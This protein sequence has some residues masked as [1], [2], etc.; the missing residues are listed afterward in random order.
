[1]DRLTVLRF[2]LTIFIFCTLQLSAEERPK[3]IT[4]AV[5]HDHARMILSN[6]PIYRANWEFLSESLSSMGYS[7]EP[8]ISPWARAKLNVQQAEADGLFLAANL[9]GRENWAVLSEPLGYG[10]FGGFYH[11]DRPNIKSLVATIRLGDGDRIL[12]KYNPQELFEVATAQ[13]GFRLLHLKKVDRLIMS[14]SYGT[15]LLETSLTEYK[16]SISF[17]D[18]V[19][20]QRSIHIAFSK[21]SPKSLEALRVVNLAIQHGIES[22]LYR[23][24]M[25]RNNVPERMRLSQ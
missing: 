18:K 21:D 24:A 7:V 13:E 6:Y 5:G 10:V 20:E 17:D 23:A 2:L 9:A 4:F 3:V 12:S 8:I 1:M 11:N 16:D 19:I 14:E 25:E 15:Y 22:G